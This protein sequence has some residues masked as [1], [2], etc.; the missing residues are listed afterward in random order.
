MEYIVITARRASRIMALAGI[1]LKYLV[2]RISG[3]TRGYYTSNIYGIDRDSILF[4]L[5]HPE[6]PDILLVLSTAGVWITSVRVQQV[7]PNRMVRRLR[8]T[9]RRFR[10][11]G[12]TQPGLD[13]LAYLKFG[14]FGKHFVLIGEFFGDGNIILCDSSGKVLALQHSINVR[15]RSLAVGAQYEPPPSAGRDAAAMDVAEYMGVLDVKMACARWLGRTLGLPRR[16]AEG[17]PRT[18][19]VDPRAAGNT[20][21]ESQARALREAAVSTI[22]NVTGG[23]HSP[24]ILRGPPPEASPLRL[25]RDDAEPVGDFMEALDRILTEKMLE[26]GRREVSGESQS[27][28]ARL[29]NVLSEQKKAVGLVRRRAEALTNVAASMPEMLSLGILRLDSAGAADILARNGATLSR[30]KGAPVLQILDEKVPVNLDAPLQSTAS[31][32]YGASKKQ[33]AAVPAIRAMISKTQKKMSR[34]ANSAA[35]QQETVAVREVRRRNWFERYRWFYTSDGDLV[36]GGRDAPSNSA[37]VRKH[38]QEGDRVFHAEVYGSPF[39]ILKGGGESQASLRETAQ[40]TVCF[41]RAWREAMHGSA[42]YWVDPAQVKKSAP[43]GEYLPKGS[44]TIRGKR[45]FSQPSALRLGVGVMHKGDDPLL[46]CGPVDSISKH[47]M[48]YVVIEPGGSEVAVAARKVRH[49][50]LDMRC[51]GA[52]AYHMDDYIRVL[53]PGQSRVTGRGDA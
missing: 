47:A 41:S 6:K 38:M 28:A 46:V 21:T 26:R 37:V 19:G 34:A 7:E 17:I 4:K 22:R 29:K 32:L 35:Y 53:P 20:L 12:V 3:E 52:D 8:D 33:A 50:L 13:R 42:A 16:Y 9:L 27:K 43:T 45:N 49:D 31:V 10:L 23:N 14:G 1:E 5:H 44:F 15:H 24:A 40:A 25:G 2:D 30:D 48:R 18:A 39:F 36:V 51:E 11:E